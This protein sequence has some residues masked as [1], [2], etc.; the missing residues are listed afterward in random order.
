MPK[1]KKYPTIS[2]GE[3]GLFHAWVTVGTKSDGTADRRHV[4]RATAG[5]VE[6]RVDELLAQKHAGQV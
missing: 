6:E 4:Q 3:D 2:P 5:E 1:K